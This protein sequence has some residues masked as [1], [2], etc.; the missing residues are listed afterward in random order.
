MCGENHGQLG[1]FKS[2]DEKRQ[3]VRYPRHVLNRDHDVVDLQASE[4]MTALLTAAGAIILF[5]RGATIS[6]R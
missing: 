3:L 6:V 4:A 1:A 5:H 2:A